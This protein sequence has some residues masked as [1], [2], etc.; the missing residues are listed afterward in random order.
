M[1]WLAHVFLSKPNID[2]QLGN[3]L[4]DTLKPDQLE[5]YS[6][7]FSAGVKC[8]YE[9]DRFTDSHD[10]VRRSKARLFAKYRHFSAV[11]VDVYYDHLLANNWLQFTNIPYRQYITNFYSA[12]PECNISFREEATRF[13]DSVVKNDRLG[14]YDRIE[15][16]SQAFCRISARRKNIG[17]ID[18]RSADRDLV[19]NYIDFEKDFMEF[20]PDLLG[21]L[22]Q[23]SPK[24]IEKV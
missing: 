12:I 24:I 2:H 9:I 14:I 18:I 20:F 8:H 17:K 21:H 3:L 23:S 11:L 4:T 15:G 16:V 1:N 5:G 22:K 7:S 13:L 10:I 19:E 6:E